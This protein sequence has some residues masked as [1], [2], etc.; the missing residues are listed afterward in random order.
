MTFARGTTVYYLEVD[1]FGRRTRKRPSEH[2]V[3]KVI[4][5]RD[6]RGAW[7]EWSDGFVGSVLWD[8]ID[9]KSS[10]RAKRNEPTD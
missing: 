1:R 5:E 8:W 2:K 7:V 6:S 3:G 10:R 9:D 4:G